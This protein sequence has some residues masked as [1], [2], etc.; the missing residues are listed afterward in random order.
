MSDNYRFVSTFCVATLI[1]TAASASIPTLPNNAP[2]IEGAI[3][4]AQTNGQE[5]RDDRQDNRGERIDDRK[6]CRQE[7]GVGK[8]KRDCKQDERQDRVEGDSDSNG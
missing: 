1:G 4:L 7:E 5:R 2:V 6:D 3:I 8:D